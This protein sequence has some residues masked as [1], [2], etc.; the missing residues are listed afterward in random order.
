MSAP[1][2]DEDDESD[3]LRSGQAEGWL[4]QPEVNAV[5]IYPNSNGD[6]VIRQFSRWPDRDGCFIVIARD[7]VPAALAI[8]RA[9][10]EGV[11]PARPTQELE[12]ELEL[13]G[14]GNAT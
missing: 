14:G 2:V 3:L 13:M 6:V 7:H 12:P 8:M 1:L 9:A 5:G 4:I 11:L 10:Y